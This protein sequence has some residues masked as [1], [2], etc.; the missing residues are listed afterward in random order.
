MKTRFRGVAAAVLAASIVLS[1]MAAASP[2]GGRD[3]DLSEKIVR[4][5][6]HIQKI[7]G[8]SSDNDIPTPPHP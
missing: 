6:K 2:Q 8:V 4:F 7:F 1:P 3:R 5:I